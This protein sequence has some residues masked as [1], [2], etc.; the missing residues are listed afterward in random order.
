MTNWS[1]DSDNQIFFTERS[2]KYDL[3]LKPEVKY[4]VIFQIS[5]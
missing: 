3:F 1:R 2:D 5:S 4:Q